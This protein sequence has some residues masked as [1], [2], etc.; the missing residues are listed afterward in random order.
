MKEYTKAS[1]V[2]VIGSV[3]PRLARRITLAVVDENV[4][5]TED[6]GYVVVE[7]GTKPITE[8]ILG[9]MPRRQAA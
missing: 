3:A 8:A 4:V 2:D 1:V 7:G 5:W 9:F 6:Q